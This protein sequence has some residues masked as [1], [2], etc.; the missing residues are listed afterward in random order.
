MFMMED[1]LGGFVWAKIN[2]LAYCNPVS[3]GGMND[4]GITGLFMF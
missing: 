2:A 3:T 1:K 4:P